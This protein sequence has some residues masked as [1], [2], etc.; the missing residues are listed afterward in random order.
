MSTKDQPQS[1][2]RT[3]EELY[4][5]VWSQPMNRLGPNYGLSGNGL[6]KICKR[7]D[8]P[9]PPRGHWAKKAAGK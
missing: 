5:E 9:Y 8:I 6:A 4:Q 2:R 1:V 3:R 7:L